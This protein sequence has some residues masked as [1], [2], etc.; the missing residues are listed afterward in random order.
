MHLWIRKLLQSEN[1]TDRLIV[2]NSNN[3]TYQLSPVMLVLVLDVSNP[4]L[5][6]AIQVLGFG[7]EG[8]PWPWVLGMTLFF[9]H[10]P[11]VTK[12][13]CCTGVMVSAGSGNMCRHMVM[14][15]LTYNLGSVSNLHL[16]L[17]NLFLLDRLD[18]GPWP[19]APSPWPWVPS[20]C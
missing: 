20:P 10:K 13:P 11:Q 2:M 9:W 7:L 1:I 18:V 4:D 5:G 16:I 14:A 15:L 8:G 6:L 12:I 19:R 3:V 17:G